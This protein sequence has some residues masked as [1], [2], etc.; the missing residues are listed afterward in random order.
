MSEIDGE[1][2]GLQR[3]VTG[4]EKRVGTPE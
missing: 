1:M 4:L 2:V 3:E